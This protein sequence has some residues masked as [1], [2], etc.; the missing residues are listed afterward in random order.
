MD[1]DDVNELVALS[2]NATKSGVTSKA[3]VKELL[4]TARVA[5]EQPKVDDPGNHVSEEQIA[6]LLQQLEA[7]HAGDPDDRIGEE[8][9]SAH[10]QHAGT[11]TPRDSKEHDDTDEIAAILAQ[12]KDEAHLEHK[13]SN[14]NTT[15]PPDEESSPFPSVSGLSLPTDPTTPFA[16]DFSTRLANLKSFNPKTYTGKDKGSI[17]VFVPGIAPTDE[18]ETIHWCGIP[19]V[20]LKLMRNL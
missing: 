2:N 9:D 14:D 20:C 4:D 17:N 13:Y 5:T 7:A 3:E 18:D 15:N 19:K 6:A 11:H 12:L 10:P 1:E 16:D 8:E